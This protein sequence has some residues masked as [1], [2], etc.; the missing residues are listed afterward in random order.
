MYSK[1]KRPHGQTALNTAH[2]IQDESLSRNET[3]PSG[4]VYL[5]ELEFKGIDCSLLNEPIRVAD[6][7]GGRAMSGYGRY[8]IGF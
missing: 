1:I 6:D 2:K 7:R 8:D 4:A 3:A 5:I